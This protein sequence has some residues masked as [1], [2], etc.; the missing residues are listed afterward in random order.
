VS[1]FRPADI[2]AIQTKAEYFRLSCLRL[3][4]FM[5]ELKEKGVQ[6]LDAHKTMYEGGLAVCLFPIEQDWL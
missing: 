1:G 2:V 3:N 6:F 4:N 5:P